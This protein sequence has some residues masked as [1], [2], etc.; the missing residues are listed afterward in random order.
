MKKLLFVIAGIALA[1]S[2]FS[3]D[4][5][6]SATT[7]KKKGAG[8]KEDPF[9][10]LWKALESAAP[11]DVIHVAEGNYSGKL[12]CGWVEFDKPLSIIG[13]YAPDFSVRNVVEHK[14]MLR[15]T[16]EMNATKPTF[17]T[18]TVKFDSN[19]IIPDAV[20]VIDG[21]IFDHGDANSY[22]P[23][24]GK[25]EGVATG[26]WLPPPAKGN[27]QFPS[28]DRYMLYSTGTFG[29]F[30]VRNCVFVN[31]SNYAV[32]INHFKGNVKLLNNLFINSR[33]MAANVLGAS[34]NNY[35]TQFEFAYNTVLFTWSR[36]NEMADMG[37]G[38]RCNAKTISRIHHNIL[39]LSVGSGFDNTKGD[40][41][42]KK[43]YLDN[44]VF[45]LNKGADVTFTISPN[46]KK[47][48][49]DSDEFED[50]EDYEGVESCEGNVSL[51]DPAVFKGIIDEAYLAS[52]LTATY[53]EKTDYN[54]NSPA[55]VFRE[56]LGMN[57]QGTITTKVSMFANRYPFDKVMKFFGAC[58]G[59]GAQAI[60]Y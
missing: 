12:S 23:E 28:I 33:M 7:G 13:G 24:K 41:K 31:A 29:D 8:T 25:P 46:I 56:A 3:A 15:P 53:S 50:I 47:I 14:T 42:S 40:A 34:A 19:K 6:V 55:N 52:F 57:K 27:T 38:V 11:M 20:T 45:F 21:L 51:K 30:I 1:A 16:N 48:M 43:L 32:N 9:K 54:E 10:N 44:N 36:T 18:M 39:G 58:K 5:Y 2:S 37:Y 17:G 60:Q 4:W 49:V 59:Y 35:D 26:M 22:H